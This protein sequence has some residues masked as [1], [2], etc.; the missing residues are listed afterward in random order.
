[1]KRRLTQH[2]RTCRRQEQRR[3]SQP[4]SRPI[5][6]V[7]AALEKTGVF[8]EDD[9][10]TVMYKGQ[11]IDTALNMKHGCELLERYRQRVEQE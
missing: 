7:A 2:C 8:R 11:V 5:P 1:M 6:Q 9:G 10:Y 3:Q 4:H